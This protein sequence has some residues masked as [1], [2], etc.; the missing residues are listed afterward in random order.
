MFTFAEIQKKTKFNR[1]LMLYCISQLTIIAPMKK[2]NKNQYTQKQYEQIKRLGEA[3]KKSIN[4]P[5]RNKPFL[6]Y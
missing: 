4:V 1:G 5:N 3:C 2:D 6:F